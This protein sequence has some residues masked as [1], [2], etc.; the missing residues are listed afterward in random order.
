MIFAFRL[1][2]GSAPDLHRVRVVAVS[3][4][5]LGCARIRIVGRAGDRADGE[6]GA[7]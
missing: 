5:D 2:V 7:R 3:G 1:P 6:R 4:F